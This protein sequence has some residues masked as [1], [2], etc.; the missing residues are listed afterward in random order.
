MTSKRDGDG[1]GNIIALSYPGSAIQLEPWQAGRFESP[2][3]D[4]KAQAPFP[5]HPRPALS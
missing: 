5:G 2:R 4:L 1:G 3:R